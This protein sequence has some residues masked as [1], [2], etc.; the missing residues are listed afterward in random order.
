MLH[1]V[2]DGAPAAISL[3]LQWER[4][5]RPRCPI[6]LLVDSGANV[7]VTN[8]PVVAEGAAQEIPVAGLVGTTTASGRG[9]LHL[10]ARDK[11]G[12][13]RK[14]DLGCL[15][16]PSTTDSIMS[17]SQH[18]WRGC[19]FHFTPV[20][21]WMVDG[22]GNEF[23]LR[24]HNGLYYLVAELWSEQVEIHE[25]AMDVTEDGEIERVFDIHRDPSGF[26]MVNAASIDLWHERLGHPSLDTVRRMFD[27]NM[28]RGHG[29]VLAHKS[30][31]KGCHCDTCEMAKQSRQAISHTR[32]EP[33]RPRAPWDRA[34]IDLCGA[35]QPDAQGNRYFMSVVCDLTGM[36]FVA[37]MPN[38][39][40]AAGALEQYFDWLQRHRLPMPKEVLTDVGG[41]FTSTSRHVA[42]GEL[43]RRRT[44]FQQIL[45]EKGIRHL[46]T[47][48]HASQLA[49]V[50]ERFHRTVKTIANSVLYHAGLGHAFWGWA[51]RHAARLV[52]CLP[53]R[54]KNATP[55]ELA[56]GRKPDVARIRVFGSDAYAWDAYG[57]KEHFQ[58]RA[59]RMIY[60]GVP[61]DSEGFLLL[62][63]ITLREKVAYRLRCV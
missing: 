19:S 26:A 38:K 29:P 14:F 22:D 7:S 20:R 53:S 21:A 8:E 24:K 42:D 51:I 60:V 23:D 43:T 41:E 56:T 37:V 28:V 34:V 57:G 54:R 30:R 13:E 5:V 40:D 50:A 48:P 63:P 61:E 2:D 36:A 27:Q 45:D 49:G 46:Q 55:F 9:M 47:S 17:I 31:K 15:V 12:V 6:W 4:T 44:R 58:A 35:F 1:P 33:D 18:A 3:G 59:R 39:S 62:D 11:L 25:S 10:C 16:M 32:R 52:N